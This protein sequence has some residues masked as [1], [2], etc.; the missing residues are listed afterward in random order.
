MNRRIVDETDLRELAQS[1]K[2]PLERVLSRYVLLE[3]ARLISKSGFSSRLLC[4]NPGVLSNAGHSM[5][6]AGNTTLTYHYILNPSEVFDRARFAYVLKEAVKY[7]EDTS[8]RY[9]WQTE[10]DGDRL[11]V[12]VQGTVGDM[13][14]PFCVY[15]EAGTEMLRPESIDIEDVLSSGETICIN[16]YPA[17]SKIASDMM[18]IARDLDFIADMG[19]YDSMYQTLSTREYDARHL[20]KALFS[21]L[22]VEN[23]PFDDERFS[24]IKSYALS[25]RMKKRW[26]SYQKK[27]K[28]EPV[29]WEDVIKTIINAIEPV[30]EAKK[31]GEVFIGDWMAELGKYL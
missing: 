30:W 11:R 22:E 29:A 8:T 17:S 31:A 18:V 1:K 3:F 21:L 14:V 24:M 9:T 20:Q 28:L 2:E 4:V 15:V 5:S 16:I 25:A 13:T 12:N 6:R 10:N 7:V 19:S 27:K 23:V 26:I